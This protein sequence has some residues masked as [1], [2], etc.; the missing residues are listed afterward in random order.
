MANIQM[1]DRN[2]SN[3][4]IVKPVNPTTAEELLAPFDELSDEDLQYCFGGRQMAL[5]A[6]TTT[7]TTSPNGTTTTTTTCG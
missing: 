6:C 4:G 2:P 7:T 1:T 3:L 5:D